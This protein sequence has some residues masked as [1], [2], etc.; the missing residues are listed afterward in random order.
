MKKVTTRRHRALR[1]IAIAVIVIV[2]HSCISYSFIY[3]LL[4]HI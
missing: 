3:P 2:L 4:K 1:N